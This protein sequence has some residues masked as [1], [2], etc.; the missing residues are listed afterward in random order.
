[1]AH[2]EN[3]ARFAQIAR[4]FM[5]ESSCLGMPGTLRLH[6]CGPPPDLPEFT[7]RAVGESLPRRQPRCPSR[8]G[9]LKSNGRSFFSAAARN[10]PPRIPRLTF[11]SIPTEHKECSL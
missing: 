3:T 7:D 5:R 9:H 6:A 10:E 4:R 1:M 8:R 2:A 11:T